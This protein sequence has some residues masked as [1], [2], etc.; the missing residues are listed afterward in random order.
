VNNL[1]SCN[2]AGRL[3]RDPELK[4][5]ASGNAIARLTLVSSEFKTVDDE[6]QVSAN[7]IRVTAFGKKAEF[8]GEKLKAGK[9]IMV[10]DGTLRT[11][12][13]RDSNNQLR[14][15]YELVVNDSKGRFEI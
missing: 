15:T 10:V 11:S 12:S 5:S 3:E 7:K 9:Q 14:V 4:I 8:V 13:Y 6:T 1:N 2:I